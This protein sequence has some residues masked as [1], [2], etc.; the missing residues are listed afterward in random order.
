G[1]SLGLISSRGGGLGSTRKLLGGELDIR[2]QALDLRIVVVGLRNLGGV[3]GAILVHRLLEDLFIALH[4]GI[5]GSLEAVQML[6]NRLASHCLASFCLGTCSL[7][8]RVC[9]HL[10]KGQRH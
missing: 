1:M 7:T 3:A 2:V 5:A 9:G 8:A 6:L 4:E 10:S